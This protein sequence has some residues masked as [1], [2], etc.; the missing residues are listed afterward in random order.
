MDLKQ[1][2]L[3]L[4]RRKW[5]IVITTLV[6]LVVVIIATLKTTPIYSATATMRVASTSSGS[7]TSYDY[8]YA[9]RLMNTY[10]K[11][12][13][14]R[15]VLDELEQKLN[16]S[17]LPPIEVKTL[18][19]TELIQITVE[20]SNPETAALA[21]NTLAE[22]LINQSLELYTGS[23]ESSLEILSEQVS[24]MEEE[25]NQARATYTNLVENSPEDT[26]AI[27]TAQ[28]MLDLKQQMYSSVLEQYEQTRLRAS[29]RANSVSVVEPAFPPPDPA[30]PRKE[31]NIALGFIVGAVGGLGLAFLFEN[32]D[33]TLYTTDQIEA[34]TKLPS[35]G[36]VPQLGKLNSFDDMNTDFS[37]GEA[38]RRLRTN[39][40]S[41]EFPV[42]TLMITSARPRE[43]KS[44]IV[45]NLA[46]VMAQS[47]R[48]VVVVDADM[49]VP[50]QYKLFNI[51]NNVGLSS[52]LEQNARFTDELQSSDFQGV[53]VIPSGPL[54]PNPSELL[55][56]DQMKLLIEKLKNTFDLVI[57]DTPAILAVA[58]AVI[59]APMADAIALVICR[60]KTSRGDVRSVQ[61][62]L[63]KINGRFIGVIENK[64]EH[65][66]GYYYYKQK[67]N[68]AQ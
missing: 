29:L 13:T 60:G 64:A 40:L 62:Q 45:A 42:R 51:E 68:L 43:G 34:V 1:Y 33:T 27:Q 54:P 22:I 65:T 38:F 52:I 46:F 4:W 48:R 41:V 35:I 6:T 11:L 26:E 49:R 15:P 21:A 55:G 63:S 31:L 36:R 19:Q 17:E 18:S 61:T 47:G 28:E 50:T 44:R 14:T 56:S 5:V 25:V 67:K 8:M 24:S 66:N 23:G 30:K 10:V 57:I 3:I 2:L 59:L 12:A 53:Y 37:Y 58:D 32:L 16:L 7:I 20:H 9:D 39:I